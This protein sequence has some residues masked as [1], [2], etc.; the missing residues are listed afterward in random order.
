VTSYV[1]DDSSPTHQAYQYQLSYQ[2]SPYGSCVDPVSQVTAS[3]AGEHLLTSITP[4]VFQNAVAHPLKPVTLGYTQKADNFADY[5]TDFPYTT[6]TNWSYLS[7]EQDTSSGAGE[8]ISYLEAHANSDGAGYVTDSQGNIIDDR[9]DPFFCTLHANLGCTPFAGDSSPDDLA[10]S[11]QAVTQ[12]TSWGSDSSALSPST[13]SYHYRLATFGVYNGS[14]SL[15]YPAGSLPGQ[16]D[17]TFD[18]WDPVT[19]GAYTDQPEFRG[20]AVVYTTSPAGDLTVD[21]YYSTEGWNTPES[22]AVNYNSGN[23]FE[24]D[25][26][27]GNS[28]SG[29]LLHKTTS[30]YSGTN[31][32]SASC[33]SQLNSYYPPCE[34][35]VTSSRT[36]LYEGTT[37]SSAP[38]VQTN[39]TYDDYSPTSGLQT[40]YHNLT[41]QVVSSANAPSFTRKWTYTTNDQTVGGTV[42]YTVDK[43]THSEVDDAGGH[44]WACQNTTY[45]E[46]APSGVPKPAAGWPTT[47]QVASN[48]S[49]FSQAISSYTGYDGVGNV[50]ASV[51]GVATSNSGLYS[52]HG[53][54]LATASVFLSPNWT[55]GRFT[56]CTTYDSTYNAL[57]VTTTNALG[58]SSSVSYD[59][60]QGELLTSASD[61]NNQTITTSYSYDSNGNR[62]VSGKAPLESGSYTSQSITNSTCTSS[63]TL[64]CFEIDSKIAQYPNAITRTFYDSLGREVEAR[65]PGPDAGHDTIVFTAYNDAAH[66]VFTSVPFEVNSGS[67]WIDPNGAVD[68]NGVAPGGS[69]TYLDALGR[70][71]ASD[72]PMLGS[73]QEP[74][75]SCPGLSGTHTSCSIY[76]LGSANG[77]SATYAY[78]ESIDP[79]N[80]VTVNFDDALGRTR[81]TQEYS[82]LGLSSLS[83]NLVQQKA[84]QYNVLDKLT[85]ITTTDLAPRPG[86]TITGVTT[87]ATYDDMGRL[88]S[89]SDPDRG[90]HTY[91]YDNDGRV[92]SDVSGTRTIGT[93]YD[94]LGRIGCIQDAAPSINATGT[95]T[96]G[97]H[98]YVQNTYDTTVLGTQGTSD[99]PVGKLTQSVATTY[100]PDGTSAMV[101]EQWQ[102]DQ[103][104]RSIMGQMQLSWPGSWGVTNPLPTYQ[105]ATS[106]NDANQVTTTT[107]STNPV[108][109]G[110]TTTNVYDSTSGALVGL[111]N[112]S[113]ANANV[114]TLTFTPRALINTINLQTTAGSA[115]ASEQFG[116][117]AN[118]RPTSTNASW[119]SGSGTS[120]TIL[121]QSRSY[122]PA[123]NVTSLSTVLSGVPGASNS[124]GS[125]T[126]NF[127]YDEQNRLIWAGNSGSQPG[128]G[129]GT[130]GNGTLFNSLNGA[131]YGNGFVYTHL[132]QLW[133]GPLGGTGTQQQ[134]LYCDSTHPH[135]L[136][137]LYQ[138]G[139][140]CSNKLGQS[141]ASGFD[142]WGNV[143]TR[144]TGGIT[145]TL[146]YDGLDELTKWDAGASGHEEYVYDAD[147]NRVLRR[148]T[149][150]G[151]TSMTVYAFGTEEH[152]YSGAGV[153]QGNT[154]YYTLAGHLVGETT[155]SSTNMF[156]TDALGS[157]ITTISAT[158]GSA[159][160]Q[161]DQAYGPYGNTRY[162]AGTM[163]TAKGFTGQYQDSTGLDY[164]GARY[165]DP[166]VGQFLSADTVEGN[167][168][169]L[170]PYAYVD[171]NP[172]TKN[173]P[174][175][176]SSAGGCNFLFPVSCLPPPISCAISPVFCIGQMQI[177]APPKVLTKW[178]IV[179]AALAALALLV[180]ALLIPSRPDQINAQGRWTNDRQKQIAQELGDIVAD[181]RIADWAAGKGADLRTWGNGYLEVVRNG[182][183]V[184]N[185]PFGIEKGYTNTDPRVGPPNETHAEKQVLNRVAI[186]I[187]QNIDKIQ[188]GDVINVL[189]FTENIPCRMCRNDYQSWANWLKQLVKQL[190]GKDVTVIL[191][192]FFRD[193]GY[194]PNDPQKTK[195]KRIVQWNKSPIVSQ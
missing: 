39:N 77:D 40:G 25:V 164:Y 49:G 4:L 147:G 178:A 107:T 96:S 135:Q 30:S 5:E 148:S 32:Q 79:N 93:N 8:H 130:C 167:R 87:S 106:F 162:Q 171:G 177:P 181:Q 80:H 163:G 168:S 121:T 133:Q 7:S 69:I 174:T 89:V 58:Q 15:C 67:S 29:P 64:P 45:D 24:E 109:Q 12:I 145:A 125:E 2:D 83:S 150:A 51:D 144:T 37:S 113:N 129:T 161:G 120:G 194:D 128:A 55:A 31:G 74:G 166:V 122:D 27:R 195:G 153:N 99:F 137:G 53:C 172:E 28:S 11:E 54:T 26:Y 20:F 103:R 46:G 48:C 47:V 18:N 72:D 50:V 100:Y 184:A 165:Y 62:T 160:V 19:P 86:Q 9:H 84:M 131:G 21:D 98:P 56:S 105:V 92:L 155:N 190:G 186:W 179:A 91:T 183:E 176:Q 44:V 139:S 187:R 13:T 117:D 59:A 136:T 170:D 193:G 154:Y 63:S 66:T 102:H 60:T 10:W 134:Y 108:G 115:L 114:A 192:V 146:S 75:V 70:T 159:A 76:G 85:S 1:G 71:I 78:S 82:G 141:Y 191:Y 97:S 16:S 101:T 94:L 143:T 43:V 68:Y 126:Q 95:C 34:V 23:V 182:Q 152:L 180:A 127:C 6:S 124:G 110:Y 65:K 81:Y 118:E 36:T 169:G 38:W 14:S 57:P 156:L 157:V 188:S 185:A 149:S 88:T 52:S 61:A 123:S 111:S 33:L 138:T 158:A 90:T 42:Y 112:T 142:A 173:D 73:S 104:G 41:Q 140:T 22:D 17:C 119:Q 3:C 116:Y 35:V 151:S 189:I 132:G 175:G